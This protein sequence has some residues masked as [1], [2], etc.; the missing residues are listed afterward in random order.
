MNKS[1][2]QKLKQ[3]FLEMYGHVCACCGEFN[4]K[5][6][7]IDHVQNDAKDTRYSI[8]FMIRVDPKTPMPILKTKTTPY[9]LKDAIKEYRPDYYQILCFN[10][11]C[12][13]AHNFGICPHKQETASMQRKR[14]RGNR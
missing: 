8:E 7:T 10:C 1:E 5:L 6:L 4:P 12:A 3:Q 2:Y 9:F 13:R 11:N 14:W